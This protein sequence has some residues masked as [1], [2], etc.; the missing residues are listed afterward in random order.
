MTYAPATDAVRQTE[1][2]LTSL[3]LETSST[4]RP[5]ARAWSGSRT[6]SIT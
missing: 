3:P 5:S 6:R 1:Q 4:S 2:F